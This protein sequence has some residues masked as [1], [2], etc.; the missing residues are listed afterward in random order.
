MTYLK[1]ATRVLKEIDWKQVDKLRDALKAL[2][3]R[4]FI[5]GV[6]GSA[7]NA[8]HAVNDFRKIANIEAYAPTDNV[9]E[10]T[11]R[12]N[13]D[14]WKTTFYKWLETSKI[15][16]KDMLLVLSV[17]GGDGYTSENIHEALIMANNRKC[18]IAGIVGPEGGST[19]IVADICIK[20]PAK[21]HITPL[22]E[23]FQSIIWHKIV[24]EL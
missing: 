23:A 2:K 15:G 11:A 6:G 24:N 7:A 13:D 21:E 8:S 20:I 10:I 19:A 1:E 3:G 22:T 12:T 18:K 9:A 17:G 14:G 5:L 4:L 16:K